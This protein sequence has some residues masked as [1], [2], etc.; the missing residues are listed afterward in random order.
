MVMPS[1]IGMGK[2]VGYITFNMDVSE[3][4]PEWELFFISLRCEIYWP[5]GLYMNAGVWVC[6][7][8]A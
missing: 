1:S 2:S 6:V 7:T 4:S 5:S 8:A 3:Y